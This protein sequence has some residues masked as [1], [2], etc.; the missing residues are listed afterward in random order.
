MLGFLLLYF[1]LHALM[2]VTGAPALEKD[3]AELLIVGQWWLPGYGRQPP[4][5]AWIQRAALELIGSPLA[6]LTLV[7]NLLLLS[8]Y[9]FVYLA[10]RHLSSEPRRAVIATLSLLLIAPLSW[11]AQRDLSHSVTV[12]ASAAAS[13]YLLLRWFEHPTTTRYLLLGLVFALGFLSKY[14]YLL[15]AAAAGITLLSTPTGRERLFDRRIMLSALVATLISAPHL[16]WLATGGFANTAV[17]EKLDYGQGLWLWS[18]L[19][20]LATAVLDFLTP[21]WLVMLLIF[22]GAFLRAPGSRMESSIGFPLLARYLLILLLLTLLLILFGASHFKARWMLPALLIVP[23]FA[24][25]ALAPDALSQVRVRRYLIAC[26]A[27]A[28]IIVAVTATRL[29]DWP[30]SAGRMDLAKRY[31]GIATAA[32]AQGFGTGLILSDRV[33]LAGNLK[34][35]LP[36]NLAAAPGVNLQGLDCEGRPDLLVAWDRK[37]NWPLPERLRSLLMSEFKVPAE[38][39]DVPDGAMPAPE[40]DAGIIV[41]RDSLDAGCRWR[42]GSPAS[43]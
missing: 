17:L 19:G 31:D 23:T 29:Y 16:L 3:E 10:A 8:T 12:A 32:I 7:K 20:S 25:S 13:F 40:L 14:N 38:V 15:F 1:A 39:L 41:L 2:R 35:R 22:R 6:A 34:L 27:A 21:W 37:N 5:Y 33:Q 30:V 4:L 36:E 42:G 28:A 26:A 24:F 11:E 43:A 18:G 9:L